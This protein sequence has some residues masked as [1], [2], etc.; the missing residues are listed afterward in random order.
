MVRL[1][2]TFMLENEEDM[3]IRV[4]KSA[5]AT[6]KLGTIGTIEPGEAASGYI[7]TIE[8]LL[9]RMQR[10]V[11][12]LRDAASDEGDKEAAKK[13]KNHL[14]KLTRVLWGQESIKITLSDPTGNSAIISPK[15]EKK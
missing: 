14:K 10:H 6:V 9:K 11:E 12:H 13:A 2:Y 8:G 7:T 1:K 3:N 4:V 15:A 5:N